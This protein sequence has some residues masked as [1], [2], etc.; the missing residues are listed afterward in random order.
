MPTALGG[1]T[2]GYIHDFRLGLPGR[3]VVEAVTARR[4]RVRD[5][6]RA[7]RDGRERQFNQLSLFAGAQHQASR[8]AARLVRYLR[9]TGRLVGLITVVDALRRAPD[10]T[11]A[12]IGLFLAR[13]RS[14]ESAASV[15]RML[16][17]S[18]QTSPR[19]CRRSARSTTTASCGGCARWWTQSFA[20]MPFPKVRAKR[21]H[22]RS[23]SSR[24]PGLPRPV[25][26]REIWV[27]S[28]ASRN[29]CAAG[30]S[31]AAAFAGRIGVTTSAKFSGLMKAQLVKN[32]VIVP[33]GAKGGFYPAASAR[34]QPRRL[35]CRR[36]RKL[37]RTSSAHCCRSP[38]TLSRTG[39]STPTTW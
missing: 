17:G 28:R 5:R 12:L 11:R 10:A 33:T 24:V 9:Q 34:D 16:R 1:G 2:L 27:Y 38:T 32:A 4:N 20:P 36:Y 23:T 30:R 14:L 29:P 7:R 25:P 19:R 13:T 37:P 39:S 6:L 21:S 35:A 8:L 15:S 18:R 26:W 31:P 22:S 3:D